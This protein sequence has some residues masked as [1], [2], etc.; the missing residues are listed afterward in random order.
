MMVTGVIEG[1]IFKLNAAAALFDCCCAA[2]P[3]NRYGSKNLL[4]TLCGGKTQGDGLE[5]HRH[6]HHTAQ[7]LT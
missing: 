3:N 2:I 4:E 5:Y 7:N 1:N 6:H